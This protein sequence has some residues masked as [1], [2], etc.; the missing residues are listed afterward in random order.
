MELGQIKEYYDFKKYTSLTFDSREVVPGSLFFCKGAA[1]DVKYL[2]DAEARGAKAYVSEVEY[3]EVSIPCVR[4]LNI[5]K[6]M[7]DIANEYYSQPWLAYPTVALTGSKGKSTTLYYIKSICELYVRECCL[8]PFACISTIDTFDGKEFFESH[9]TTPESLPLQKHFYNAK[10]ANAFAFAMEVSSQGLKYD[11]VRGVEFS[12][13]CF[14]NF[15]RDHIGEGEHADEEDYFQSKLRLMRQSKTCIINAE[16]DR[17]PEVLEAARLNLNCERILT[18]TPSAAKAHKDGSDVVFTFDGREWRL[19]MPG[20]FNAENAICAILVCRELGIDDDTIA[21]GLFT[22]RAAGRMETITN[23][24]KGI[25]CIVD[26]AH[27]SLSY[28]K[29]F[30][31]VRAEYPGCTLQALFGCPGGKGLSRRVDLPKEAATLADYSY[32]CEEDPGLEDPAEICKEVYKNLVCF[33]GKGEI[34]VDREK[35]VRKA[36]ESAKPGTVIVFLGKG[37]EGY[38]HRGSDYVPI[39]SEYDMVNRILFE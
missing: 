5:R 1:F 22:A 9:L 34:V 16:T 36:I 25:T 3:P 7:A 27:S 11:R 24:D 15:G 20:L 38:M 37:R 23:K 14:L 2:K 17:Y 4:V 21:D 33:G 10:Q 30:E 29:L 12:I 32:I 19:G 8:G 13:G 18:Y 6:A 26:Y 31:S 28:R 35:A 39:E